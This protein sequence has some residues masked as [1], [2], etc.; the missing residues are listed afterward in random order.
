MCC[1]SE[2]YALLF[3]GDLCTQE[4]D[5]KDNKIE[6]LTGFFA[7]LDVADPETPATALV[8]AW[9][10]AAAAASSEVSERAESTAVS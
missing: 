3:V 5:S 10:T 1:E 6:A 2:L 9:S 8:D 7:D 4:E